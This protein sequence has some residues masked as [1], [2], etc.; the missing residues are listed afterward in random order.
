MVAHLALLCRNLPLA[1]YRSE[2]PSLC[3]GKG[4]VY[5]LLLLNAASRQK[6]PVLE[7]LGHQPGL[8]LSDECSGCGL[9]V[10]VA[11]QCQALMASYIIHN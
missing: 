8:L 3:A 1:N 10:P 4:A 11:S 2:G 7:H 9:L 5:E 6:H